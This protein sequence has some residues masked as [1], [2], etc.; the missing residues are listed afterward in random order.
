MLVLLLVAYPKPSLFFQ[1]IQNLI[2]PPVQS[3]AVAD[4]SNSL[5]DDPKT[6]EKWVFE[7]IERDANDYSN[8]GVIFYFAGPEEVLTNRRG[9]CYA[10]AIL[11]ASILNDKSIPYR[12]Y[13]MPGHMWVNY[14]GREPHEWGVGLDWIEDPNNAILRWEGDRWIYQG[15]GWIKVI[16]AMAILQFQLYWRIIPLFGKLVIGGVLIIILI[17]VSSRLRRWVWKKRDVR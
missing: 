16:P 9:A 15:Y 10:R 11:L 5:P 7:N 1:H 4:I 12:I 6:V 3:E 2:H 13:L 17:M 8:W 14:E